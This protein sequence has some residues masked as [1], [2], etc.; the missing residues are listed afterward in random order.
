[1]PALHWISHGQ[2]AGPTE[3]NGGEPVWRG[4]ARDADR[5]A[6]GGVRPDQ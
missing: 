1:M 4:V 6:R 3:L 5:A 2:G